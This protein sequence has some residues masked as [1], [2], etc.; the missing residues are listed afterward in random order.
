MNCGI[1]SDIYKDGEIYKKDVWVYFDGVLAG[2]NRRRIKWLCVS[3]DIDSGFADH[4]Y[5]YRPVEVELIGKKGADGAWAPYQIIYDDNKRYAVIDCEGD[6]RMIQKSE[7]SYRR[8]QP[9]IEITAKINGKE[10]KLSDISDE[11]FRNLKN[12]ERS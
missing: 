3:G 6:S 8:I 1:L 5:S 2:Q 12:A 10:A 11:T 4:G 9:A 7:W